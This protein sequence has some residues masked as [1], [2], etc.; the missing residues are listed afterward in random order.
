MDGNGMLSLSNGT[1]LYGQFE[2]NQLKD[3]LI[4]L[5]YPNGDVYCGKHQNGI[6]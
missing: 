5:K 6:K 4:Q 1:F 3:N 2:R